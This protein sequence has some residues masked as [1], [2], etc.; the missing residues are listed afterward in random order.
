MDTKLTL[1]LDN[2][3]IERAKMYARKKNTSISHLVETYLNFLTNPKDEKDEITPLVKSLS[4][5][6]DL[7]KNFDNK[8]NYKKHIIKKYSK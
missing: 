6:I 2:N 8:K 4:G 5:I 1:K 3:V 7:P